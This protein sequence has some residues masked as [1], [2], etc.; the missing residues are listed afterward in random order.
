MA[1]EFYS[2]LQRAYNTNQ[3]FALCTVIE[4]IGSSPGKVGQKMIV[5]RDGSIVGTVGGGVN[6][7]ITRKAALDLFKTGGSTIVSFDMSNDDVYGGDPVCGGEAKVLIELQS[8]EPKMIVFGAGHIG[9][10]L[11]NMARLC[12]FRVTIADE[13]PEF[14]SEANFPEDVN[15]LCK[16]YEEAVAEV[17]IDSNSFV[18]VATPG[19]VKDR[20]VIELVLPYGYAYLGLV[21]SMKKSAAFKSA[22]KEK[23]FDAK[24]VDELFTPIGISLGSTTPEEISI[25]IMSQ[26]VAFR[27]GHIIRFDPAFKS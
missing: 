14:A 21:G 3:S 24:K 4:T 10:I 25:E 12:R 6:E 18:V 20:E 15:V 22:L 26:I 8:S 2:E 17:G 7:D 13:R 9:K 27:N 5:H 19:H 16:S 23:G 11:A 1:I